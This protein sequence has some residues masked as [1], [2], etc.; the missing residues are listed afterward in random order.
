MILNEDIQV[1]TVI[2][3]FADVLDMELYNIE[4]DLVD[5]D[6][7]EEGNYFNSPKELYQ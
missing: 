4:H 5:I 3:R 1:N 2:Q 6:D 7:F